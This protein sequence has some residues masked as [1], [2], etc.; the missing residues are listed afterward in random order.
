MAILMLLSR[1]RIKTKLLFRDGTSSEVAGHA[2]RRRYPPAHK[3]GM[4]Q[5]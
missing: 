5:R 3:M 4:A 2:N 1:H